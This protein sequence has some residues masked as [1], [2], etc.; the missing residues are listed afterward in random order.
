MLLTK[1]GWL[2]FWKPWG[3]MHDCAEL[4]EGVWLEPI[5][6]LLRRKRN[7]AWT[8]RHRHVT[9]KVVVEGWVQQRLYDIV[10]SDE[11]EV[12]AV[13]KKKARRGTGCTIVR[14]GGNRLPRHR[15]KI[16]KWQ[17]GIMSHPPSGSN[18]K[19]HLTVRRWESEKYKTGECSRRLPRP[20]HHRWLSVWE[21]SG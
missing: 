6:A 7:E 5:Q 9:R 21:C 1:Q 14:H 2:V 18:W 12:K 3:A 17:D 10:C 4:T 8:D 20:R 16:G 19:S 15:W 11:K 13:T